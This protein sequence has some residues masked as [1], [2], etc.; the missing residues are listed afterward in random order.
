MYNLR[1]I[2][3]TNP[4][5]RAQARIRRDQAPNYV[6]SN[7]VKYRLRP[8]YQAPNYVSYMFVR[9]HLIHTFHISGLKLC[10]ILN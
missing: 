6:K 3:P 7:T 1:D 2:T 9:T 8:A 10:Q 4:L 5:D